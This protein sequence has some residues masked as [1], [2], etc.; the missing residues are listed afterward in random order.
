LRQFEKTAQLAQPS[1]KGRIAMSSGLFNLKKAMSLFGASDEML[2]ARNTDRSALP[3]FGRNDAQNRQ[4]KSWTLEELPLVGEQIGFLK[5]PHSPLAVSMFM[6]KGGVLKSTLTLNLARLCALHNIKTCVVG[7]DMQGDITTAL[8]LEDLPD[9]SASLEDAMM[10][11]NQLRGLPDL[12]TGSAKLEELICATDIPSLFYIPETPELVALYQSLMSRNRREYWLKEKVIEPLK[13]MFDLIILDCSP[14]WNR[15]ITNALVASD[16]L[17]S[18]LECKINNFRNLKAFR[19]LLTEFRDDL[20]CDFQ[21]IYVPTRLVNNR[22]LSREIFDWYQSNLSGCI[23]GAVRESAQG[24]ESVA[25]RVS[26]PEHAPSSP[27]GEEMRELVREIWELVQNKTVLAR[28]ET[29]PPTLTR[30]QNDP[31]RRSTEPAL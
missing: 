3:A 30:T 10:K 1:S 2:A 14:N 16:V 22:K 28:L 13:T 21:H 23:E 5:R 31:P 17:V 7:L 11:M 8:N 18:P 27:A 29:P 26:I 12:Y 19:I 24:E 9:E 20:Q 6:T 4:L 25:L 15:L